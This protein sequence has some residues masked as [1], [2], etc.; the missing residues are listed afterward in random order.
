M[1]E[2]AKVES[3]PGMNGVVWVLIITCGI[4]FIGGYCFYQN[5][6]LPLES[7]VENLERIY[8]TYGMFKLNTEVQLKLLEQKTS[9][10][11]DSASFT[12]E[13]K[14]FHRIETE[15]GSV[16]IAYRGEI[17]RVTDGAKL[18]I[19]LLNLTSVNINDYTI[20]LLVTTKH[21][22]K[23][24]KEPKSLKQRFVRPL[25]SGAWMYVELDLPGIEINN[26][27]LFTVRMNAKTVSA[28]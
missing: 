22:A 7:R 15:I 2:Q 1:N 20:E 14:G 9:A 19:N 4:L 21:D 10:I 18:T 23:A 12:L 13:S 6:F 28:K 11:E 8:G 25:I 16:I 17:N 3:R 24:G 26:I 5:Y 27:E